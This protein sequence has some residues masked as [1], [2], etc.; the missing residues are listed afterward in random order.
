MTTAQPSTSDSPRR[1]RP[2]AAPLAAAALALAAAPL[3]ALALPSPS[4]SN[5]QTLLSGGECF[6]THAGALNTV[7][8]PD[9]AGD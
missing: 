2:S 4:P 7:K 9:C 3:V 5:A 1:T 6:T 8:W